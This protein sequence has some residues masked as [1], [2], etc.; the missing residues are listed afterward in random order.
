VLGE[1]K[2]ADEECGEAGI[3]RG[4]QAANHAAAQEEATAEGTKEKE[5]RY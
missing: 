3:F 5:E 4:S 2:V 1:E